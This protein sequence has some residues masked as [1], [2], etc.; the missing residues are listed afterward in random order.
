MR[1]LGN[2]HHIQHHFGAP[3]ATD[4]FT[5][6]TMSRSIP[7]ARSAIV[8]GGLFVLGAIRTIGY[9]TVPVGYLWQQSGLLPTVTATPTATPVEVQE[10]QKLKPP[11]TA[12]PVPAG[13]IGLIEQPGGIMLPAPPMPPTLPTPLDSPLPLPTTD[14]GR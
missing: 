14:P 2:C 11:S 1:F 3:F 7:L 5:L 8:L 9:G 10:G 13:R 4:E 6:S 12:M